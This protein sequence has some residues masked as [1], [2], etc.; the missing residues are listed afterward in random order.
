VATDLPIYPYNIVIGQFLRT[1]TDEQYL[2]QDGYKSLYSTVFLYVANLLRN[3]LILE[4]SSYI[5]DYKQTDNYFF[6]K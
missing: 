4:A 5:R 3:L 1:L 2:A 6:R